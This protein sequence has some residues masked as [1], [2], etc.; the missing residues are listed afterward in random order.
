M[1]QITQV[2]ICIFFFCLGGC[3]AGRQRMRATLPALRSSPHVEGAAH[4]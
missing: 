2:S 3:R 4:A 1:M